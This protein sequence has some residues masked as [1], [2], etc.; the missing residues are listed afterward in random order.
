MLNIKSLLYK[1]C[2]DLI[3]NEAAA[4]LTSNLTGQLKLSFK[5]IIAIG[6]L[7]KFSNSTSFASLISTIRYSSG[8]LG[9]HDMGLSSSVY[10]N[11][12]IDWLRNFIWIPHRSGGVNGAASGDNCD[13]GNLLLMGMTMDLSSNNSIIVIRV[14][15]GTIAETYAIKKNNVYKNN[16]T[17]NTTTYY[18]LNGT[19]GT[20]YYSVR[21]GVVQ[22]TFS[23]KCNSAGEWPGSYFCSGLPKP[24][25]G[26]EVYGGLVDYSGNSN[27]PGRGMA[28]SIHGDGTV[29]GSGGVA[30][31][32]YYGTITYITKDIL[33]S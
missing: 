21:G 20:N 18:Q 2:N 29:Y 10:N 7:N 23:V 31:G 33:S 4:N 32:N 12:V 6:R 11:Q 30:G 13:Y 14:N 27:R 1:I 24:Y 26:L 17:S 28:I 5:S 3:K 8:A 22:A 15:G 16:M 19:A 25:G 9:S